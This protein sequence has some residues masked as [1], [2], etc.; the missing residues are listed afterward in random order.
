MPA[1]GQIPAGGN[2][3][4]PLTLPPLELSFRYVPPEREAAATPRQPTQFGAAGRE[5]W[6]LGGGIA[7]NFDDAWDLNLRAAYSF[8][9]IDDVEFSLELNGWYFGQ[10]GADALGLNPAMVFRWHLVNLPD[11]PWSIFADAGIGVL[12]ATRDVPAGGTW[13]DFTPRIGAGYTHQISGDG[14][15]LQIGAR[16]HHISNA[17]ISGDRRNP[18]RDGLMLYAGIMVPF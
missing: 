13:F 4:D 7:H 8:F 10:D 17:R 9:L 5:Y 2:E 14:T 15:R 3:E 1:F 12:M 11:E 16:W 6:T 18:A